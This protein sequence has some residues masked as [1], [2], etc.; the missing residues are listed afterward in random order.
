MRTQLYKSL[1]ILFLLF[2]STFIF[3]FTNTE[4]KKGVIDFRLLNVKGKMVSLKDY[5]D[6]TFNGFTKRMRPPAEPK[7][8]PNLLAIISELNGF[9][10]KLQECPR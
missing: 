1:R 2:V 4:D 5:P 9:R 6:A 3:S 10:L 7:F 8:F